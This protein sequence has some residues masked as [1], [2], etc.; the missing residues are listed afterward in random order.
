MDIIRTH[1]HGITKRISP[2]ATMKI[3]VSEVSRV[4]TPERVGLHETTNHADRKD[5][6]G[7]YV[8]TKSYK[9]CDLPAN[10]CIW[11]VTQVPI[12]RGNKTE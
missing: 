8:K 10:H 7:P 1:Y 6:V 9:Q 3:K 4:I 11:S 2:L 12:P 5:K